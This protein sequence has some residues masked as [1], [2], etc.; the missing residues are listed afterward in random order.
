M[1][2]LLRIVFPPQCICCGTTVEFEFGLCGDCWRETP[3]VTGLA[4]DKCGVPLPG[5]DD[6][7]PEYCDDCLSIARPWKKGRA[8]LVYKDNARKLVLALKHGDRLEL[9]RPLATWMAGIAKPLLREDTVLVP[10]PAHPMRLL[11]RKYN[12]AAVLA[13]ATANQ[14]QRDTIPDLL[15][16][17]RQTVPHNK[18]SFEARFENMADAIKPSRH[19]ALK[20]AGRPVLL[21]DDV[22]TSGATMAAAADACHA[23]GARRVDILTLARVTKDA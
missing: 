16:R 5:V 2:S 3:F 19:G 22:V 10:I 4:C 1:Q 8:A 12:Q 13:N 11:K 20:L 21:I 15:Q 17:V 7:K 18:M 9:S 6:G 23:L 14:V